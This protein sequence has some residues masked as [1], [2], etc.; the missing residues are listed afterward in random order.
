MGDGA[1]AEGAAGDGASSDERGATGATGEGATSDDRAA[2]SARTA[3]AGASSMSPPDY[4]IGASQPKQR[5]AY[6]PEGLGAHAIALSRAG[7]L[8]GSVAGPCPS[9]PPL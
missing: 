9:P 3:M 2:A 1:T 7:S 8:A 5:V 6:T 4:R